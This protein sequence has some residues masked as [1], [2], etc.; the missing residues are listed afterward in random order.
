MTSQKYLRSVGDTG[1]GPA[2]AVLR[3]SDAPSKA[4]AVLAKDFRVLSFALE[5]KPGTSEAAAELAA[6]L[7]GLKVAQ[8]ALV[9]DAASTAVAMAAALANP[10]L[11]QSVALVS[12][13]GAEFGDLSNLKAPVLALFGTGDSARAADAARNFCRAIPNCRLVYVYDA[14][15]ALDDARPEA[16]AAA[17]QDFAVRREK[18]LVNA[19]S[20]YLYP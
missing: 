11:V 13:A 8:T 14:S 3:A 5:G 18:F 15:G 1:Q 17:L 10:E 7:S 12:P 9:A 19:R 4:A 2:I 6:V 20:N 16:V